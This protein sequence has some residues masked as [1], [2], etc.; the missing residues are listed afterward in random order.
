MRRGPVREGEISNLV[1]EGL[2][3]RSGLISA[4]SQLPPPFA[5]RLRPRVTAAGGLIS[6]LRTIY[7][8]WGEPPR[9][10]RPK[11]GTSI[12]CEKY[13]TSASSNSP[14]YPRLG[15]SPAPT[16][17]PQGAAF[18]AVRLERQS[19]RSHHGRP[20]SPMARSVKA[21]AM[22]Q[23]V[24]APGVDWSAR[25]RLNCANCARRLARCEG[26]RT[27]PQASGRH[28]AART[29]AR[30]RSATPRQC[31]PSTPWS[32]RRQ[33]EKKAKEHDERRRVTIIL[34]RAARSAPS[35]G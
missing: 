29:G 17:A 3:P 32:T 5:G 4:S 18:K 28:R 10:I 35:R 6:A 33:I 16:P 31:S 14:Q 34:K 24:L 22:G 1:S 8:P 26:K 13:T 12:I 9:A 15:R 30:L 21:C 23:L 19:G 27:A 7:G 25:P 2:F 20:S 11:S